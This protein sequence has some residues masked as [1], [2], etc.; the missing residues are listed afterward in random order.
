LGKEIDE[1]KVAG[2]RVGVRKGGVGTQKFEAKKGGRE[3]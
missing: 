2:K 1:E 3:N